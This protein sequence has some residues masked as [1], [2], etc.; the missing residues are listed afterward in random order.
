MMQQEKCVRWVILLVGLISVCLCNIWEP[1][2]LF[3]IT[4]QN[5]LCAHKTQ[6]WK[7][8]LRQLHTLDQHWKKISKHQY[9]FPSLN[10]F[11][12]RWFLGFPQRY[13]LTPPDMSVIPTDKNTATTGG[14]IF[15]TEPTEQDRKRHSQGIYCFNL[16]GLISTAVF[17]CGVF[18]YA[19][20]DVLSRKVILSS[21]YC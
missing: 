13:C 4:N 19:R 7:V 17:I 11:C 16:L 2:T 21:A 18:S 12:S 20:C 1:N 14:N 10:C 5:L 6:K 9:T 15:G 3:D 8:S